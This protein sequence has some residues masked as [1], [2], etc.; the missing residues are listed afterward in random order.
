MWDRTPP[1]VDGE[2]AGVQALEA[3]E[4]FVAETGKNLVQPAA[5]RGIEHKGMQIER[6]E[7]IGQD[8]NTQCIATRNRRKST[9]Y[10]CRYRL[11]FV[12]QHF[13][14]PWS[15]PQDETEQVNKDDNSS[16]KS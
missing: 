6:V 10:Y 7:K 8:R 13:A 11:L 12:S 1:S 9:E 15:F 2:A 14:S 3:V 16:V 5:A 4:F